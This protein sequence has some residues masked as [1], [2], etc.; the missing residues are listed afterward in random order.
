M[1]LKKDLKTPIDI[2]WCPGCG[3]FGIWKAFS[4]AAVEKGW[5][6]T[7][8]VLAAGIGCHGHI[9]NFIKLTSFEGLHGRAIPLACGI[10]MANSRLNVFVFT[11]DGDCLA[12]GGNHFING[13]RRNHDI[14]I[15]LHDN[16]IYGL[17]TGQASPRSPKNKKTKSTPDGNHDE[18][19]D[20]LR[21]ALS[22]GATF[23]G[24]VYAGQPKE[25]KEMMIAAN[26]HKGFSV[27]QILQPCVTFDKLYTHQYFRENIYQ[28]GNDYDFTSREAAF[29]K[30]FEWGE[31][32][33]PVGIFYKV[34]EPTNESQISQIQQKPLIKLPLKRNLSKLLAKYK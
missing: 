25:L 14:T 29:A 27:V 10:K 18:P 31:K 2:N 5:D 13:A 20:P 19:I 28:L 9:V 1:T 26:E 34:D 23:L 7:N 17:T 32:K 22:A 24:R 4:D 12:E 6:N 11:G 16:A 8:T 30:T 3:N 15:I 33:I 21:L